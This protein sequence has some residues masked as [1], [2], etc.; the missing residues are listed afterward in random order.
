MMN[1]I[2]IVIADDEELFRKGIRFLLERE[3]NFN[4]TYEAENGKEL[5]DFYIKQKILQILF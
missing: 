4:I 1:K 5:I 2:N 3:T